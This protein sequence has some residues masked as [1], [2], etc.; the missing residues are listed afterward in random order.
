G[1]TPGQWPVDTKIAFSGE[2]PIVLFFAHPHCPCT[3]ASLCELEH[4]ASV[5]Q[6]PID[7]VLVSL[8]CCPECP[9]WKEST[10]VT[11]AG[12][13]PGLQVVW[14]SDGLEADRFGVKT[15]GHVVAYSRNGRAGFSGGVTGSRGHQGSNHG[16]TDLQRWL[17]LEPAQQDQQQQTAFAPVYGCTMME[18]ANE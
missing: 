13:I 12:R 14:D 8:D 7:F 18:D 9:D 17:R 6:H 16:R 10:L 4:A 3:R 1:V 11:N 2:R 15:S 5:S